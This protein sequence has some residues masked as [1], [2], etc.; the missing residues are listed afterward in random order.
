[1]T[2]DDRTFLQ[3]LGLWFLFDVGPLI[4]MSVLYGIFI[5]LVSI[6]TAMF[7]QRDTKSRPKWIMFSLTLLTFLLATVQWGCFLSS[8]V[9]KIQASIMDDLD[10]P[11]DFTSARFDKINHRLFLT[12]SATN[13]TAQLMPFISDG[14]VVWRAWAVFHDRR[15]VMILPIALLIGGT[16]SAIAYYGMISTFNGSVSDQFV[17]NVSTLN[18]YRAAL[19][20]SLATNV[21]AT[22]MILYK[23]WNHRKNFQG[24]V[25]QTTSSVQKVMIILVETGLAFCIF[26]VVMI[27]LVMIPD[28]A[29]SPYDMGFR[30]MVAIY[31]F[32]CA[33]YPTAV[34]IL[35]QRQQSVVETF[36]LGTMSRGGGRGPAFDAE[37]AE[38]RPAVAARDHLDF[39]SDST[40]SEQDQHSSMES[41]AEKITG[42]PGQDDKVSA[43]H[44]K[45]AP[46]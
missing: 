28:E 33:M 14:I 15:R 26:Q 24:V 13:W 2:P 38:M 30:T 6:S 18:L 20:L 3:V 7:I 44:V 46:F 45:T 11:L 43:R 12:N 9:Y 36:G 21:V 35:V 4:A 16:A 1:M 17:E 42:L 5:L 29:F 41:S 23:L 22:S 32:F 37:K 8:F 25:Y 40:R 27:V 31:T 19:A 39:I 10:Q 34:V